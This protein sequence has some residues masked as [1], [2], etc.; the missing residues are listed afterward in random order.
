[1]HEAPGVQRSGTVSSPARNLPRRLQCAALGV[2]DLPPGLSRSTA[3]SPAPSACEQI[4]TAVGGAGWKED[5][6]DG[7]WD[8]ITV[9]AEAVASGRD[10]S[11][12]AG[13]LRLQPPLPSAA[14]E[15]SL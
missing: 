1:A 15:R 3:V 4:R 10:S 5:R 11:L 7:S 8:T 14:D 13:A 12:G 6:N 2:R 9:R